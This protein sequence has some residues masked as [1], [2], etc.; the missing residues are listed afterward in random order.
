MGPHAAAPPDLR[1]AA[2]FIDYVCGDY[3]RAV[4]RRGRVKSVEELSEHRGFVQQAAGELLL[5]APEAGSDLREQLLAVD[6]RM[7]LHAPPSEVVPRLRAIHG[8]LVERFRLSLLP[9][10]PPDLAHA[11]EL[12]DRLCARCHGH[13]GVPPSN[14]SLRL[15]ATPRAFAKAQ[16][17]RDLSPQR[18]FGAITFGAGQAAEM[19]AWGEA[20]SER[21]R[22]SLAFYV[23]T[24]ARPLTA[25]AAEGLSLA[26]GAGL[27]TDYLR[28]AVLTNRELEEALGLA[29]LGAAETA[30]ALA[31]LRAAPEHTARAEK[32]W[33]LAAAVLLGSLGLGLALVNRASRRAP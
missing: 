11:K 2:A 33:L 20:F 24:F 7:A 19:P 13:D 22:W 26:K 12:F 29:G 4:S 10:A 18:A 28:L 16:E 23:L 21:D 31:V 3:R 8:E 27:P 14:E 9:E 1:K 17:V 32:G 5:K 25:P 6:A 15:A 30:Q